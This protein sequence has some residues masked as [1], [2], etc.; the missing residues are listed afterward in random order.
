MKIFLQAEMLL[1]SICHRI[2]SEKSFSDACV[3]VISENLK[4]YFFQK[5]I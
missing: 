1:Q 2:R 3:D 4:K 5:N